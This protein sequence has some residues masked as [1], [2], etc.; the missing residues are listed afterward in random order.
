MA[1]LPFSVYSA[2][3]CVCVCERACVLAVGVPGEQ[4]PLMTKARRRYLGDVMKDLEGNSA[5]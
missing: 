2:C 1:Y 5:A 3:V 4:F